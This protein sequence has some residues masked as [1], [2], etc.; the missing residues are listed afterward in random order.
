M[1][2]KLFLTMTAAVTLTGVADAQK[3]TLASCMLTSMRVNQ[4]C[5]ES[6]DCSKGVPTTC[7]SKQ[8]ATFYNP[9]YRDCGIVLQTIE[10]EYPNS[11]QFSTLYESCV[12]KAGHVDQATG[13]VED[14][15][16]KAEPLFNFNTMTSDKVQHWRVTKDSVMGGHSKGTFRKVSNN[17]CHGAHMSGI[18]ELKHGGFVVAKSPRGSIPSGSL[19]HA[20]GI[21]V[22]SK[23][24]VD[25]GIK[26]G[27]GDMYKIRLDQAG[28]RSTYTADFH[29]SE[30][31]QKDF[32]RDDDCDGVISTLPFSAFWPSH[33]GR[34]TGKQGSI[35]PNKISGIGFDVSFV[36]ASGDQNK[37]LDHKACTDHDE[38]TWCK[39]ENPFGLCVQWVQYYKDATHD[40]S[41]D[42]KISVYII[43]GQDQCGESTFPKKWKNSALK[44]VGSQ[45][46]TAKVGT[47]AAAGYTHS[48]GS[49]TLDNT[50]APSAPVVNL[51]TKPPAST[52]Y[53]INSQNQCGES[54]FP[55]R[56]MRISVSWMK[57]RGYTGHEGTCA[58]QGYTS[59]AGSKTL[60]HTGH[61]GW[62]NGRDLTV[63]LFTKS[64]G[65]GDDGWD[66]NDGGN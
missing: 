57:R 10:H 54:T 45:G 12:A 30:A 20:D 41:L 32:D 18:I 61:R 51:Y 49:K 63:K 44:W 39:N 25:Y 65:G 17:K 9:F 42:E 33:W 13:K 37:E 43:N 28:S 55:K 47:C 36:T 34:R 48:A 52:V 14:T 5:C 3:A 31:G 35:N 40:D 27:K 19:A 6:S 38:S 62:N 8:C 4:L 16:I 46:L 15:G 21:R 60:T 53:F 58:Q 11:A 59:P 24:T 29:T 56:W 50:G 26:D 66:N 2:R 23:A 22:C 64:S 1:M 7:K